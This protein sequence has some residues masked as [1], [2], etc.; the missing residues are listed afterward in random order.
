MRVELQDRAR[1]LENDYFRRQE[2]ELIERL[3]GHLAVENAQ[4]TGMACPKCDGELLEA[5]FQDIMLDVCNGCHGVWFDAGEL[6]HV[7]QHDKEGGWFGKLF[8]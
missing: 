5:N 3:K 6:A 1:A 8:D 2:V 7:I 4:S